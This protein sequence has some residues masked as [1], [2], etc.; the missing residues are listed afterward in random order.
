MNVEDK[1]KVSE[2]AKNEFVRRLCS[3]QIKLI[4]KRSP[5]GRKY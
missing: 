5:R 4:N 3:Y 2:I 1:S